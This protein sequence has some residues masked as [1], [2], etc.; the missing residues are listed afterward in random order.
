[1][2]GMGAEYNDVPAWRYTLAPALFG[3]GDDSEYPI[4]I[5]TVQTIT[6][7]RDLLEKESVHGGNGLKI[8]DVV[9]ALEDV[10]EKA[11]PG[12]Q[13]ASAALVAKT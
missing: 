5:A 9:I 10:P 11:V 12:L 13:R 6:E 3:S 7:L 4:F 8:V 2:N 1:M